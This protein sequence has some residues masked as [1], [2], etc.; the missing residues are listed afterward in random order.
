MYNYLPDDSAIKVFIKN[1]CS[2]LLQSPKGHTGYSK[3]YFEADNYIS[4]KNVNSL[5][6]SHSN[7]FTESLKNKAG[8]YTIFNP[9]TKNF[10]IGATTNFTV[11]L[12]NHYHG[13]SSDSNQLLYQEVKNSGGFHNFLWQA[14][15]VS[16]NYYLN[17][18]RDNLELSKDYLTYRILTSFTQYETRLLEQSFKSFIKPA[19]NGE[20]DVTLL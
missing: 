3:Y 10:Y 13:V 15:S 12:M 18:I 1:N 14:T 7:S 17:F 16:P 5:P 8:V 19:L 9:N 6:I 4:Y 20:G 11:R 2:H